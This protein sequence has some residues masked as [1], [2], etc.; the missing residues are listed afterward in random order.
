MERPGRQRHGP[1]PGFQSLRGFGVDWS[2]PGCLAFLTERDVSIPE[3]V[4]GGLEPW[5]RSP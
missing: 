5:F 4:W 2:A 3:R 1:L